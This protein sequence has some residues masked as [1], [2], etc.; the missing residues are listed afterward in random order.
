MN[1]TVK[2]ATPGAAA[3]LKFPDGFKW[4]VATSSYQIEGAPDEDGKGS[5]SWRPLSGNRPA[6]KSDPEQ[7]LAGPERPSM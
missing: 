6:T 4:G 3:M 5:P 1:D 2:R 7:P